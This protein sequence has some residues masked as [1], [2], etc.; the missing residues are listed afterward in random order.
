MNMTFIKIERNT[1]I[2]VGE[3]I[4]IS[5]PTS[6]PM[7]RL[8]TDAKKGKRNIDTTCGSKTRSIVLMSNGTVFQ[9]AYSVDNL[10]KRIGADEEVLR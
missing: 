9:S 8:L 3:I 4:L 10:L 6:A 1:V 2:P 7:K 5:S